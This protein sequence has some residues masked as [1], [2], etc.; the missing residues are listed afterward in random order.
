MTSAD[1]AS[2]AGAH[3]EVRP[4]L[5]QTLGKSKQPP[6]LTQKAKRDTRS[7]GTGKGAKFESDLKPPAKRQT[8]QIQHLKGAS[9]LHLGHKA[10]SNGLLEISQESVSQGRIDKLAAQANPYEDSL[11]EVK[12]TQQ[13]HRAILSRNEFN[14]ER[15]RSESESARQSVPQIVIKTRNDPKS[16]AQ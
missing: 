9:T 8:Q 14:S 16:T 10:S 12:S 5:P 6:S 11:P 3:A 4:V 7:S 2:V 15:H 1:R 13:S